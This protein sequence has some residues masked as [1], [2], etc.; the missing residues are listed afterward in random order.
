[1]QEN[2]LK[3]SVC[4]NW[5]TY[6]RCGHCSLSLCMSLC[7][8]VGVCLCMPVC[9]QWGTDAERCVLV[10][11]SHWAPLAVMLDRSDVTYV[12]LP[13][14][15]LRNDSD[16]N[17]MIILFTSPPSL[18]FCVTLF[19]SLILFWRY[20]HWKISFFFFVVIMP[21]PH[22]PHTHIISCVF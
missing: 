16:Q 5:K 9:R 14:T 1:M 6:S 22:P 21:P 8:C 11:A 10:Y 2:E 12:S 3:H 19:L 4:C 15:Q 17:G 20:M 7:G 13:N 18:Y